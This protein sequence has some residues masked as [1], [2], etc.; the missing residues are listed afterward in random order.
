MI[1]PKGI[2]LV[3]RP[4][5]I[6]DVDPVYAKA[7]KA[8]IELV[9]REETRREQASVDKGRVLAVGSEAFKAYGG[10]PWCDVGDYIAYARFAGKY[11]TDPETDEEVL[12]INDEDVVAVIK[13]EAK[14]A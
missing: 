11:I 1:K 3:V 7:R 6:E 13:G 2:G 5:K 12:V 4:D 9:K 8:G 10:E 14:D